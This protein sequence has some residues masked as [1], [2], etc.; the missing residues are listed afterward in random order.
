[1]KRAL[2]IGAVLLSMAAC[3]T[4]GNRAI[5]DQ[6]LV[7]QIVVGQTTQGQCRALIGDPGQV[8]FTENDETVW[9]YVYTEAAMGSTQTQTLTV[10]FGKDGIVKNVGMGRM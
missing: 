8:H 6:S 4:I 10:K 2:I 1:M 3:A 5:K 9:Y 7:D